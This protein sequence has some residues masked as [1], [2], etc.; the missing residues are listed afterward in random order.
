MNSGTV[1]QIDE[2]PVSTL[3]ICHQ[4]FVISHI[5]DLSILQEHDLIGLA[6]G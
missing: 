2:F 1:L 3:W 4:R 5:F 6:N